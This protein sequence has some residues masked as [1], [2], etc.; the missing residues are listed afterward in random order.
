MSEDQRFAL[1]PV[2]GFCLYDFAYS[3]FTTIVGTFVFAT[4]FAKG[5]AVDPTTGTGQWS[6]AMAVA[7]II[8]AVLSPMCGAIADQTGRR[9]RWLFILSVICVTATAALWFV[10]PKPEDVSFALIAV[11]VATVGFEMATLFYNA[12]MPGIAPRAM[13]GRISGWAWGIGYAGGLLA[14]IIGLFG[15]V[16]ANPPPF[17][18]D[19]SQ[20]EPVRAT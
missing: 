16:Q 6:L 4:Y 1:A 14:L 15:L 5:V 11:V 9:K 20:A 17:G 12:L 3:A 18:L 13:L 10:E 8:V 19:K 2:V 7:G